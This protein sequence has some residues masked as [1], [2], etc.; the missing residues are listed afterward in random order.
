MMPVVRWV[1]GREDECEVEHCRP[2]DVDVTVRVLGQFDFPCEQRIFLAH[3]SGLDV[4]RQDGLDSDSD[5]FHTPA[6]KGFRDG[7][8]KLTMDD[9]IIPRCCSSV[10][11]EHRIFGGGHEDC[12]VGRYVED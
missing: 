7:N 6:A 8:D 4:E 2:F 10:G 5:G 11:R 9:Y 12:T 3:P 1:V